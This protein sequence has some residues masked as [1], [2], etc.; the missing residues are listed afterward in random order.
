MPGSGGA[1]LWPLTARLADAGI[2]GDADPLT[3]WQRLRQVEGRRATI[4]DLYALVAGERGLA[5]HELPL[6]ERARLA[7]LAVPEMWPGFSVNPAGDRGREPI[8]VV[9]YDP[10]WPRRY[11]RW[12]K[13]LAAALGDTALRIEHVGSTAVPGL[14]AKPVVD[15]QVSVADLADEAAYVAALE[16]AGAQLR[17]RDELHAYFRPFAGQPREVHVHV[18]AAGSEWEREHL[19][20]RDYLR[21]HPQAR[22]AYA[23]A[24]RSAVALW[25]DDRWGYTEAKT[26]VIL[27][28]LDAAGRWAQATGWALPALL[29]AGGGGRQD[30]AR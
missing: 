17:S 23:Q 7:Q 14:A 18:C 11:E 25:R 1:P 10:A 3:A 4:I 19:V 13:R 5:A 15:I 24:K 6:A 9:D 8:E 16:A 21:A 20:F 30:P 2:P 29:P 28:I 22:D 26:G 27:D 12:R